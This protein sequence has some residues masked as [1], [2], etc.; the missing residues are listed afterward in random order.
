VAAFFLLVLVIAL[1]ETQ[2]IRWLS[3]AEE[4]F[5]AELSP[6]AQA[7]NHAASQLGF[8]SC[9]HFRQVGGRLYRATASLW[10]SPDLRILAVVGGGKLAGMPY[11]RT[12]LLSRTADGRTILTEDDAGEVDLSGLTD[13]VFLLNAGLEELHAVHRERLS[14]TEGSAVPFDQ[15]NVMGDYEAMRR[16]RAVRLAE[17]GLARFLRDD[18]HWRYTLKGSLLAAYRSYF[19]QLLEASKQQRRLRVKRPGD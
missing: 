18:D 12:Q 14:T 2:R 11:K 8:Q 6:Y 10:L 9:G 19:A 3:P 15:G 5:E 1:S 4:G 16:Q 17:M 13:R 7:V